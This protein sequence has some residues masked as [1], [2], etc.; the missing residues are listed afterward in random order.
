MQTPLNV[1]L[2]SFQIG[3]TSIGTPPSVADPFHAILTKSAVF[4]PKGKGVEIGA[5]DGL[6]D[7]GLFSLNLFQ[8]TFTRNGQLLKIGRVSTEDDIRRIFGEP[9]WIDRSDGETI[10]F[11][12]YQ[13]GAI[14]LQFEFPDGAKLGFVT[15]LRNGILSDSVDRERYGVDKAWPP[16]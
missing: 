3:S 16:Q 6:L 7:Y 1:D 14:E 9:Y 15:L 12:E 11:Y 13:S 10:L 5:K 8:G 4:E 2:G